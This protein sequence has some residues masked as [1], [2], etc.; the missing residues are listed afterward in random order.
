M[1]SQTINNYQSFF[2]YCIDAMHRVS[3][4]LQRNKLI[5]MKRDASRLQFI[6]AQ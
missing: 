5:S 2:D 1:K 4:L 3:N 6:A